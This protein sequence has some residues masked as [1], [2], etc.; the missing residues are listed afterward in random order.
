ML[1][2]FLKNIDPAI[3]DHNFAIIRA[4]C[5]Q[6]H[7]MS[8]SLHSSKYCVISIQIWKFIECYEEL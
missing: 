1:A 6:I 5:N 3:T 8:V 7:H 2:F 4:R